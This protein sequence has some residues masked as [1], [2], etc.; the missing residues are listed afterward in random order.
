MTTGI[1]EDLR[2]SVIAAL[3]A[4]ASVYGQKIPQKTALPC[5]CVYLRQ[6]KCSKR[7]GNQS[8]FSVAFSVQ[9]IAKEGAEQKKDSK[10]MAEKALEKLETVGEETLFRAVSRSVEETEDGYCV[11]A[12]YGFL[13]KQDR[14]DSLMQQLHSKEGSLVQIEV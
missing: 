4:E 14:E 1:L 6:A 8:F 11:L 10:D 13:A 12:E 7:L 2:R 9:C 3:A 5:Y